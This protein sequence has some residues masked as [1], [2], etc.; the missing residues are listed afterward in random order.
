MTRL[1]LPFGVFDTFIR[2]KKEDC[3]EAVLRGLLAAF[4]W[5]FSESVS[6]NVPP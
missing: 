2:L 4:F 5:I 1:R 6:Q 3:N